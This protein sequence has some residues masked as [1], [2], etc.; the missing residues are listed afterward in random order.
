MGA[1]ER[2]VDQELLQLHEEI[3]KMLERQA[4]T[5]HKGEG[6]EVTDRC[7][8]NILKQLLQ[9]KT[10]GSKPIGNFEAYIRKVAARATIDM[11]RQSNPSWRAM[12][13]KID[14]L[15]SGFM[16]VSG[17]AAWEPAN[18]AD[19][20]GKICGFEVW[21]GQNSRTLKNDLTNVNV[22]HKFQE[23]FLGECNLD[24]SDI[25]ELVAAVLNWHGAP[26]KVTELK[27]CIWVLLGKQ[28]TVVIHQDEREPGFRIDSIP[29]P[30]PQPDHIVANKFAIQKLV[31]GLMEFELKQRITLCL[32]LDVV[33]FRLLVFNVGEEWMAKC[34]N[35]T[36]DGLYEIII[37]LPYMDSQIAQWIGV[38]TK[39]VPNIRKKGRMRLARW[40]AK[41]EFSLD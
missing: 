3:E 10:S 17:F 41:T 40:A 15:L 4:T 29:D 35:V 33:D 14:H 38:H 39:D 30:G 1:N 19:E 27:R 7:I 34:L 5:Q 22:R 26:I 28:R 12:A 36:V 2:T 8:G 20:N 6:T 18:S 31:D 21:Q 25:A 9:M 32:Q 11:M 13:D 16:N 37:Q 24:Q 23:Q